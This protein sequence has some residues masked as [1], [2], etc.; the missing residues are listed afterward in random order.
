MFCLKMIIR[1]ALYFYKSYAFKL[2]S[3]SPHGKASENSLIKIKIH[4]YYY[5]IIRNFT[6]ESNFFKILTIVITISGLTSLSYTNIYAQNRPKKYKPTVQSLEKHKVPKWYNNAKLGIFIHWGLYSV[7]GWAPVNIPKHHGFKYNP[8][9]EWFLNTSRIKGSPTQIYKDKTYGKNFDYYSFAK[10]FDKEIKKW[11]PQKWADLFK[12]VHARYVVLTTK[13]HEGFLLWPSA[14]I[15]PYLPKGERHASR[16]IVGELTKAVRKDGMKMGYYY[17]GGFDW[18]FKPMVIHNART[19][20]LATPETKQYCNYATGQWMELINKYHPA[21]LWN[22]IRW[23]KKCDAYNIFAHYYNTVPDGVINNRWGHWSRDIHDFTTPEYTEYDSITTKKWEA[24]RGIALSFGY[25]RNST[26]KQMLSVN[27]LV[28]MFVDIV[29]KNGNLLLDVGPE[30]DGTIP[31]L[32]KERLKGLGKWLDTNGE[33]IFGTRPWLKA[34]TKTTSGIPI[35]FTFKRPKLYAILLEKP[36]HNK[37]T[38]PKLVVEKGTV[39]R[40][41][42]S[43]GNLNWHNTSKGVEIILPGNIKD[44]SAYSIVFSKQPILMMKK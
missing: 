5:N 32:Q 38:I 12:S 43:K 42:G 11:N 19:F 3:L 20:R 18:S 36:H 28:D 22:D 27:Q 37:I 25:N 35:R 21:I 15:D 41:L 31:K 34:Q 30:A 13:H 16:D 39:L 10:T 29:S 23:P 14:F 33:A 1:E 7:P 6:S 40:L 17:S 8:Y 24:T 2:S 44:E 9:A 4:E 26:A